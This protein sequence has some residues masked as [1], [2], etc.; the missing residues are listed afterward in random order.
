MNYRVGDRYLSTSLAHL[1]LSVAFGVP[2]RSLANAAC[3][4]IS[5]GDKGDLTEFTGLANGAG[6]AVSSLAASWENGTSKVQ[7][8]SVFKYLIKNRNTSRRPIARTPHQ[9]LGGIATR[10][11]LT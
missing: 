3:G 7:A 9:E 2:T 6:T 10:S 8:F 4:L 1:A 5:A 11:V